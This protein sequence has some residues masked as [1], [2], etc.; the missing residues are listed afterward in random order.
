[1]SLSAQINSTGQYQSHVVKEGQTLNYLAKEVY[2]IT[3]EALKKANPQIRNNKLSSGQVLN[4]PL[5]EVTEEEA[6]VSTQNAEP[7]S[8]FILYTVKEGDTWQNLAATKY[9]IT[10]GELMYAN[11]PVGDL[12]P[13]RVIRVP[14][15]SKP[16]P[17]IAAPKIE[18]PE[19]K[20]APVSYPKASAEETKLPTMNKPA[21][22]QTI[23]SDTN[24]IL[25][26][27]KPGETWGSLAFST[28][29][30]N[31][32]E[33]MNA[34]DSILMLGDEVVPGQVL[35][36]PVKS[37]PS[38]EIP[39]PKIE[40][41]E[42][43]PALAINKTSEE[44]IKPSI[45]NP[46]AE[47]KATIPVPELKPKVE[48]QEPVPPVSVPPAQKKEE[49][50]NVEIPKKPEVPVE[51][52]PKPASVIIEPIVR[53]PDT[54]PQAKVE[55]IKPK[56]VAAESKVT[57]NET[58]SSVS[59]IEKSKAETENAK[60]PIKKKKEVSANIYDPHING[61]DARNFP[62]RLGRGL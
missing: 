62:S 7:D 60:E 46:P 22:V 51:T 3:V 45:P 15:K 2:G 4:I 36:I 56:T 20:P 12:F 34:N 29:Q 47:A 48:I 54:L 27:V 14:I 1:M 26:V 39:A 49:P 37:K 59:V 10:M 13:G 16:A 5:P 24:Y 53:Q 52:V 35:R 21:E 44:E 17:E 18:V 61:M 31:M 43:K 58:A 50:V 28:Y 8:N 38:L 41:E 19:V 33:L 9:H 42:T 40:P 11:L 32:T 25:H 57:V 23:V 6:S 55:E 30:I